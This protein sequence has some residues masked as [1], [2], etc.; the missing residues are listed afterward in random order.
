MTIKSLNRWV[1]LLSGDE[2]DNIRYSM[3]TAY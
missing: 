1:E 3:S 2:T